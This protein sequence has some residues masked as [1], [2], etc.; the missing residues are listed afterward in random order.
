[1]WLGY[2]PGEKT[3]TFV[4]SNTDVCKVHG[5]ECRVCIC[6]YV[7]IYPFSR[8]GG[9]HLYGVPGPPH[10]GSFNHIGLFKL[11]T[12]TSQEEP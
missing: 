10:G 6:M 11:R 8:E 4:D 3:P 9:H 12:E 1:M 7:C 5:A 2:W